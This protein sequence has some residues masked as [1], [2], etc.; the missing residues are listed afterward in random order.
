M[1]R[2]TVGRQGITVAETLIGLS[3]FSL[4]MVILAVSMSQG[5]VIWDR[6]SGSGT[7]QNALRKGYMPLSSDLSRTTFQQ[8]RTG[9]GPISLAGS[10]GDALWFLSPIDPDT[11][12]AIRDAAGGPLWQRNILY[13][14][15]VPAGHRELYGRDCAGN[16]GTDGYEDFCPHKMLSRK[17]IDDPPDTDPDSEAETLLTNVGEYLTRPAGYDLSGMTG[18]PG[19]ETVTIEAA[20]LT[21]FRVR[22]EPDAQ[23]PGEV[24]M[25]LRSAVI[26]PSQRTINVGSESPAAFVRVFTF[27]TFPLSAPEDP[28]VP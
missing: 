16:A 10:D 17:V 25:E 13:Y 1:M 12:E 20:N 8:V 9:P 4:L 27:S 28:P 18:E 7:S 3:V 6:L 21:T 23:W 2:G 26:P 22:L 24:H 14:T 11:N 5:I 15:V 19:L